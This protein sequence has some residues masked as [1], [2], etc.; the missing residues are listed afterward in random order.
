MKFN[1]TSENLGSYE[2][3]TVEGTN[4]ARFSVIPAMGAR[5]NNLAVKHRGE[6]IEII[7][8]YSSV[9]ELETELYSKSSLL[10]PFPN[11]VADGVYTFKGEKYFLDVNKPDENNAIHGFI[12]T[13][14]FTVVREGVVDNQYSL[15]LE[16]TAG[17]NPGY[18]FN[19]KTIVEYSFSET[20]D[21]SICTTITNCSDS[22]IPVGFGWHPYFSFGKNINDLQFRL[23][24]VNELMV[25]DRLIPTGIKRNICGWTEPTDI[26]ETEFDTGFEFT[27]ED[28]TISLYESQ[29]QIGVKVCLGDNYDYVQVFTPPGRTSIAIEPMTCGADAFNNGEG[30]RTLKPKQSLEAKFVISILSG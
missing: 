30:L 22:E 13:A 28:K 12:S 15:V 3:V 4:G 5:L 11:R 29:K 17:K 19:F 23:P 27:S 24:M 7:D 10:A 8:G 9:K 25:D 26:G 16:Y 1:R 20:G 21:L 6:S 18:P 2:I 14:P